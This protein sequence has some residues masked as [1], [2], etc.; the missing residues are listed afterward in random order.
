[1]TSKQIKEMFS[2]PK[3]SDYDEMRGDIFSHETTF[4][5]N[6]EAKIRDGISV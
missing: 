4:H 5:S 3:R 6:A 2:V 1:M